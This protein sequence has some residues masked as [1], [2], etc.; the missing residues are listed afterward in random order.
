VELRGKNGQVGVG[1][2]N[3][4]GD[5]FLVR[6]WIS[7]GE[8]FQTVYLPVE[9]YREAG[10]LIVQNGRTDG[11]SEIEIR[12]VKL[13]NNNPEARAFCPPATTSGPTEEMLAR[14]ASLPLDRMEP[15]SANPLQH[16]G[17]RVIGWSL[18]TPWAYIGKLDLG[19]DCVASGG[20]VAVELRGKNGQV[21]VGLLNRVGD[22]F[23]VRR[24]ISPGESFQTVYLPVESYREASGLIVQNGQTDGWSGVEIRS[25]KLIKAD[26][27]APTCHR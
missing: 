8:S 10:G 23:L 18:P 12:S 4:A 2:L 24:W 3:R 17:G 13:I 26:P 15:A 7:P 19:V 25:V 6:R 27:G 5:K 9:S 11:S 22:E 14:A 20:W 21:G 16:E 1:L